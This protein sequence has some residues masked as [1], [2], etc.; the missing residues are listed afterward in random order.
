MSPF[1]YTI[2]WDE[3]IDCN[4]PGPSGEVKNIFSDNLL[5]NTLKPI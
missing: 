1:F 3:I 2:T 4:G 5:Q